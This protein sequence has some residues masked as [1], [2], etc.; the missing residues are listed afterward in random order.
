MMLND[1]NLAGYFPGERTYD[2]CLDACCTDYRQFKYV[3]AKLCEAV[4]LGMA[5]RN[6][7]SLVDLV[8]NTHVAPDMLSE[9]VCIAIAHMSP[10]TVA[11][12][13]PASC[14]TVAVASAVIDTNPDAAVMLSD[15]I[16]AQ[17]DD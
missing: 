4:L 7:W 8:E 15:E 9:P 14:I 5:E 13:L 16:L 17:L 1:G 12:Y 2:M 10:F 6:A 11:W 3:P